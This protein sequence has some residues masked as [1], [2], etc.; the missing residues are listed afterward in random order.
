MHRSSLKYTRDLTHIQ[1]INNVLVFICFLTILSQRIKENVIPYYMSPL[2]INHIL[3][4]YVNAQFKHKWLETERAPQKNTLNK[5]SACFNWIMNPLGTMKQPQL[6]L[7]LI[8]ITLNIELNDMDWFWMDRDYS[9]EMKQ[10]QNNSRNE[11]L[12][13]TSIRI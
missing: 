11:M 2:S 5:P 10:S 7:Y 3:V 9:I 1:R 4:W 13:F 8:P 6:C 12:E